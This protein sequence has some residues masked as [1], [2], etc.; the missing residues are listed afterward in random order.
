MRH[1]NRYIFFFWLPLAATWAMMALE[2]PFLAA[3]IARLADPK[4][5]LAAYGVA[6]ALAI[7]IEAPVIMI[8]SAA[9]ALVEDGNSYRK[10]RN[11]TYG[12]SA[13]ATGLLLLVLVPP[14]YRVLTS[15]VM[16]LPS[17][18]SE[19]MYGALWFFL[20]W[21]GAIGYRRFL[22]GVLIR[23]GRTRLVAYGTVIR[24]L[25]MAITAIVLYI[26]F[27]IPG[28]W[29]AA[30]ALGAGVTAE[31]VA[32]RR[33]AATTIRALLVQPETNSTGREPLGYRRIAHFYYPLALTSLIGLAAHPMLAFFMSRGLAPIESLAVFPVV[34]ALSF[35]FRALGLS[36]QEA[37]I[38]LLGND[39]EHIGE[40]G[41]F[42]LWLGLA[43]SAGLGAVAFTPLAGVWFE[44]ISGLTPELA[45]FAVIPT[46]I[47][48]PLPAL[49]VLLSF[50]RAVL[51]KGHT[52]RPITVAT[53]IEVIGIALLF[54]VLGWGVGLVGVTAAFLAFLG[55]RVAGNVYL[56]RRCALVLGKR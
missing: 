22:Q 14:V 32:A 35:M 27:S 30:A 11:F 53:T 12:L 21:P 17:E 48:V 34:H 36:F 51:V 56:I 25:V 31:A 42:G 29:V 3:L 52:T 37:A 7:L 40:L 49:S 15:T 39:H 38:A 23:S 33:M 47:L 54:V 55:G 10:L 6:F 16:G 20:P 5:N 28:V 45:A 9:T 2:G 46:M 26:A 44:S 24:V 18:V 41:R 19:L 50:Q 8:M 13:L 4:F 1:S 43:S